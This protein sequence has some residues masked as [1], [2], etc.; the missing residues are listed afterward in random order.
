LALAVPEAKFGYP[1]VLRGLVAAMVMPHLLRHVGER[2]ARYLLLTGDLI[3]APEAWTCGLINRIVP[4][5]ELMDAAREIAGKLALGGPRALA[6]T[7]SL[8]ARC[9]TQ[10]ISV[11]ELAQASA[12]PRLTEE[13]RS[14]LRAFFDAA[15]VPW[16]PHLADHS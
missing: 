10:A 14:G 4:A 5:E 11:Q 1:E 3:T 13:C 6:T 2:M 9:S 12:E 7:K 8:L 16:A 15:P